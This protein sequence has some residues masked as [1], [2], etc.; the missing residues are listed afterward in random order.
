[1]HK[2][3]SITLRLLSTQ[4]RDSD[5]LMS[6][7]YISYDSGATWLAPPRARLLHQKLDDRI[8]TTLPNHHHP[9]VR[10]VHPPRCPRITRESD[11]SR[12]VK[13]HVRD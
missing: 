9:S 7:W 6:S 5:T 4:A 12:S 2:C 10:F 8:L 13:S 1:M 3:L 11:V